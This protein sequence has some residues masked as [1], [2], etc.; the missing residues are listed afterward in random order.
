ML[1]LA[2]VAQEVK[3]G[4]AKC[5]GVPEQDNYTCPLPQPLPPLVHEC[6]YE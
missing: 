5:P 6:V 2:A 4:L 3:R 1:Q